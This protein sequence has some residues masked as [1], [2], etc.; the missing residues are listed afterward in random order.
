M[1]LLNIPAEIFYYISFHQ[2]CSKSTINTQT[3][4]RVRA[5]ARESMTKDP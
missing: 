5:R 1:I 3:H 2:S 4:T